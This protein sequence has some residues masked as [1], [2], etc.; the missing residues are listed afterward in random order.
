MYHVDVAGLA[1]LPPMKTPERFRLLQEAM[2]EAAPLATHIVP[3][4][5]YS[6]T[7]NEPFDVRTTPSHSVGAFSEFLRVQTEVRRSFEP[8]FSVLAFG[9]GADFVDTLR[10]GDSFGAGSVFEFLHRNDGR[11]IC[12]GC[13]MDRI[14]FVHYCEQSH[15]INYRY[16][17]EFRGKAIDWQGRD[18]DLVVN[19]LVR[20]YAKK[21]TTDL[22]E[23]RNRLK[24]KGRLREGAFG[25]VALVGCKAA[26]FFTECQE[27]LDENSYGLVKP[28][29][30]MG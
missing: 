6:F 4:F 10:V 15:G 9:K 28:D 14:T 1:Q 30:T 26:E 3:G 16:P 21:L 7:R 19:Y 17:K 5:S 29:V 8:N 22:R 11:I 27:I 24:A 25:R 20:D 12:F 23:L 2:L 18:H 13:S